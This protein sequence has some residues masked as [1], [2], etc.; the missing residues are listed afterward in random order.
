MKWKLKYIVEP[1]E[2][3]PLQTLPVEVKQFS[4]WQKALDFIKANPK[5]S[6]HVFEKVSQ[7]RAVACGRI[8]ADGFTLYCRFAKGDLL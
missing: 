5:A 8:D 4:G 6:G 7:R 1:E 2:P 3:R